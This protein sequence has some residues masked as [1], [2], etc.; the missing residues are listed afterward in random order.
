MATK[1]SHRV[2]VVLD[3]D[4]EKQ[5]EAFRERLKANTG[6]GDLS[7]NQTLLLLIRKGLGADVKKVTVG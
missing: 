4:I 6:I 5:I 7:M 2:M 3:K 1:N